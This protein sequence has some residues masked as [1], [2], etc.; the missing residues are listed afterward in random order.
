MTTEDIK[1]LLV[2]TDDNEYDISNPEMEVTVDDI[3]ADGI[4]RIQIKRISPSI[5]GRE[6]R[7][8]IIVNANELTSG[9]IYTTFLNKLDEFKME[10]SKLEGDA[11]Q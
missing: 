2:I 8:D 9:Q 3:D 6:Y 7:L 11:L 1:Q 4:C 5:K 10:T